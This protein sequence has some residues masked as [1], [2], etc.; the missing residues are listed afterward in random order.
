[1]LKKHDAKKINKI[2]AIMDRLKGR[3]GFLLVEM[4]IILIFLFELN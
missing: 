1:M 3:E 4:E 2:D